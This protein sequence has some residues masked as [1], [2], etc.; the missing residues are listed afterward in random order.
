MG[1]T[2]FDGL[3]FESRATQRK[4]A[5]RFTNANTILAKNTLSSVKSPYFGM[6]DFSFAFARA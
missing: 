3:I 6:S 4:F 1:V 5:V 2:C